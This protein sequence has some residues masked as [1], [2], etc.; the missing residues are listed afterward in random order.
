M[1]TVTVQNFKKLADER[2]TSTIC[3]ASKHWCSSFKMEKTHIHV[4]TSNHVL[5]EQEANVDKR[6]GDVVVVNN[7]T[8][9]FN[10]RAVVFL[11]LWYVFSGCTLFL[12][13]YILKYLDGNPWILGKW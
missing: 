10:V 8:G 11:L 12:N 3:G 1:W 5:K 9:L 13:K 6:N 4:A 2:D 7:K